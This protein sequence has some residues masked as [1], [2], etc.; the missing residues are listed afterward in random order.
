[1]SPL[2]P[3]QKLP[4]RLVGRYANGGRK[5]ERAQLWVALRN[6][7]A[8]RSPD[9]R[10]KPIWRAVAFVAKNEPVPIGKARIPKRL[11]ALCREKPKPRRAD[12]ARAKRRPVCM[13]VYVERP[14]VIHP[15][16]AQGAVANLEAQRVNQMQARAR[17][18]AEPTDVTRIR[19]NLRRK[20]HDVQSRRLIWLARCC[21]QLG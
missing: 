2:K 14:P 3:L 18:R 13:F 16:T 7:E 11:L 9:F 17:H 6:R 8:L 4:I 21:R 15:R 1:M 12:L 19:S 10:V 20:E 5:I